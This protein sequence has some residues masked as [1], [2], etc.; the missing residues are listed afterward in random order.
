LYAEASLHLSGSSASTIEASL[1]NVPTLIW[2]R[3]DNTESWFKKYIDDGSVNFI[4]PVRF[5][6]IN[7]QELQNWSERIVTQTKFLNLQDFEYTLKSLKK[8]RSSAY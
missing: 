8:K 4:D 6:D 1:S 5:R 3:S 7:L 2:E